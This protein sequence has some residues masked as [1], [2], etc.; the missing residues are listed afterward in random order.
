MDSNSDGLE[1]RSMSTVT[2]GLEECSGAVSRL[3]ETMR[4]HRGGFA[5]RD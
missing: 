3:V 1:Q 5:C 4:E 2:L